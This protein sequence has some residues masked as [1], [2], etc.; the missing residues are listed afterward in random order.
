MTSE[1]DG[2]SRQEATTWTQFTEIIKTLEN[3][4]DGTW[5]YR[6]QSKDWP[7]ATAL[8]DA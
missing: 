2:L 4:K 5:I 8:S 1:N 6:G 3:S 7:L